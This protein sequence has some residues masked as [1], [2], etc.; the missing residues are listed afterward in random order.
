MCR[1][2]IPVGGDWRLLTHSVKR[3]VKIKSDY[4]WHAS[5]FSAMFV[6]CNEN[7]FLCSSGQ[8]CIFQAWRCDGDDDCGDGSDEMNCKNYNLNVMHYFDGCVHLHNFFVLILL[9]I[10]QRLHHSTV[11][12]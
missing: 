3:L 4:V 11:C 9:N 10:I 5:L 12:A 2:N 7:Q 1:I 8:S 6:D